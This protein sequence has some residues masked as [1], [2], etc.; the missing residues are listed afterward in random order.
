MSVRRHLRS[1][2]VSLATSDRLERLVLGTPGARR[3]A[4]RRAMR[5]VA[6][7]DERAALDVVRDLSLA[8][9]AAS[10]DLFGESSDDAAAA[11]EVA[12]RF[13]R[14]VDLLAPYPGT[15]L[16]LDCSHLALDREPA[17]CRAR[18]ERIA[19]SLPA[20]ARL[21]LGAEE[22][23][24]A[25]A[26]QEL[27]R[28]AAAAGAP[29]ML[30]VQANLRRSEDDIERLAAS[31]IPIRLVKGAY[32]EPPELAYRWGAETDR[33]FV[34]LAGRL[35]ELGAEHALATHDAVLLDYLLAG[36]SGVWV[37]QLLGVLPERAHELVAAGHHVRIYVPYGE[38]WFRY[39]ARRVA[40]S[41][42]A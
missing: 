21:Q 37:E 22:A 9:I 17:A 16:S 29:V 3:V 10:V 24:R 5:Y 31:R 32:A 12:D 13:V 11:D 40:E 6:G 26:T 34:A 1:P 18:V 19:A 8:G 15:Y 2:A 7:V 14:L 4:L 28:E 41:I 39:Y 20:G 27:A 42:G 35:H 25:D 23:S 38:R 33:A 30:T 36:R